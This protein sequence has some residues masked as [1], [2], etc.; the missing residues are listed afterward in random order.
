M[1][2]TETEPAVKMTLLQKLFE[3]R[4][5]FKTFAVEEEAE[6]K[7]PG[8]K[9]SAYKYTPGWKIVEAFR[10]EMD[11][12]HVMLIPEYT[13][14]SSTMIEYPVYKT[15]TGKGKTFGKDDVI[16]FQKRTVLAKVNAKY[17]WVDVDSGETFGPVN[18]CADGDNGTDKSLASAI[19]TCE[20][21]F[22]LK[23][24]QVTTREKD[25]EPDARDC[26][27]V[28]G[29]SG[30][31]QPAPK[32]VPAAA[33]AYTPPQQPQGQFQ[34]PTQGGY[35]YQQPPV[36]GGGRNPYMT[37]PTYNAAPAG[38]GTY[39]FDEKQ[40]AIKDAAYRL[41]NF[42]AGS[43]SHSQQ[44]S[45]ELNKLAGLGFKVSDPVFAGNLSEMA[46]AIREQRQPNYA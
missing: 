5:K 39:P 36:Q 16:T 17:T 13:R 38:E 23:F 6:K 4:K 42:P 14:E 34:Q 37:P 24:F 44:L 40:P 18:F 30:E 32:T 20:R 3:I 29:V 41:L 31:F 10:K 12:M 26:D 43:P 33:P 22:L 45:M 15:A 21:Q 11:E 28:P 8:S 46:Q 1:Q 27:T 25:D 19:S 9:E 35:G 7:I 2:K